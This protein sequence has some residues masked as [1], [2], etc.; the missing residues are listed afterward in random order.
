MRCFQTQTRITQGMRGD[1]ATPALF[2]HSHLGK[3]P[4]SFQMLADIQIYPVRV[5]WRQILCT[6]M[7]HL[8]EIFENALRIS[9]RPAFAPEI[10]I[11]IFFLFSFSLF[12]K[13]RTTNTP[14]TSPSEDGNFLSQGSGGFTEVCCRIWCLDF[15]FWIIM[16]I[17]VPGDWGSQCVP[18]TRGSAR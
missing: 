12:K 16:S 3:N 14:R 6:I 5:T 9:G 4:V 13:A 15:P 8:Y 10:C 18:T 11:V 2:R 7:K 17:A 1:A